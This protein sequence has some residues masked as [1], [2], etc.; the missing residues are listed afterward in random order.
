LESA[1]IPIRP[2]GCDW[3]EDYICSWHRQVQAE[4]DY[5]ASLLVERLR[6]A[7]E[8]ITTYSDRTS[9]G[10]WSLND[11]AWLHEWGFDVTSVVEP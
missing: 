9:S 3:R 1:V 7:D 8:I 5:E 4:V 11:I 10:V 6:Q 2:C